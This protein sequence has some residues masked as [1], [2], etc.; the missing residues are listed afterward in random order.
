M[1]PLQLLGRKTLRV[2]SDHGENQQSAHIDLKDCPDQVLISRRYVLQLLKHKYK[3]FIDV[4]RY[5]SPHILCHDTYSSPFQ[6]IVDGVHRSLSPLTSSGMVD[7]C[8]N[9]IFQVC[10]YNSMKLA[11]PGGENRRPGLATPRI[12]CSCRSGCAQHS[13]EIRSSHFFCGM[14]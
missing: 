9:Y 7:V 4:S 2:A 6:R 12:Q 1:Y 10:S 8:L 14:S 11:T 3:D 5:L 13:K